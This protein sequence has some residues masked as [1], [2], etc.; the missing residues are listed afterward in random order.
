MLL[1]VAG[2]SFNY[3]GKAVLNNVS[4]KVAE[5]EILAILGNNGAGKSTLLKCLSRNLKIKKGAVYL[6]GQEIF[7]TNLRWFAGK[8][9]YMAQRQ[10]VSRLTVF[11]AVLVGR[12]PHIRLDAMQKDLEVVEEVL[13][14]LEMEEFALRFLDELSGG[15]LQKVAVARL[16]A[17][18]PKLLL[19]DE[20][21][22]NL[23]LR[24]QYEILKLLKKFARERK[25]TVIA[26]LHDLNQ[27]LRFADKFLLIKDGE[28]V[29]FGDE[30]VL[31]TENIYKVYGIKALVYKIN[32]VPVVIPQELL[33]DAG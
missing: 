16:L 12:R 10:E 18:E 11:D 28:I 15:E 31:S 8:V 7:R 26:I 2:V 21:T 23:D 20:P 5:G 32:N 4:F 1:E 13:K 3:P 14:I 22:S 33:I 29:A 19:L 25:M 9:G 24:H 17:Q 27:A 30:K 6:E